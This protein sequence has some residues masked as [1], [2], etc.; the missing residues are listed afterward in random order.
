MANSPNTPKQ[1][2][3][4]RLATSVGALAVVFVTVL[5]AIFLAG[6][7]LAPAPSDNGLVPAA[8]TDIPPTGS[9]IQFFVTQGT[10][11]PTVGVA[12]T[13]LQAQ[14]TTTAGVAATDTP[15]V[16]T[17]TFIPTSTSTPILS[18]PGRPQPPAG[19]TCGAPMD[20]VIYWV[21]AN[22][23]LQSL[24]IR[25]NTSIY[26]LR[27]ANCLTDERLYAGQRL[28]L[29]FIPAPVP[30]PMGP[31]TATTIPPTATIIP[32]TATIVPPTATIIPPTVTPIPPDTPTPE[33]P[34]T[35]TPIQWLETPVPEPTATLSLEIPTN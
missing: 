23:T 3:I 34:P 1:F 4:Q 15:P 21:Q 10:P 12:A 13:P 26:Q 28:Y 30:T 19:N 8:T 29:P 31:P 14:A 2:N 25:T 24:A 20:W 6:K 9:A 18:G 16:P 33:P 7:D 32:P 22:D 17:A 5:V 27:Q 11:T 35:P